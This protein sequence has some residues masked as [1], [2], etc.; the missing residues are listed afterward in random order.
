[1]KKNIKYLI[2]FVL[3]FG[4]S[5][6]N[7][8]AKSAFAESVK[9]FQSNININKNGTVSVEEVILYDFGTLQK[10]GIY[11]DIDIRKENQEG[12]AFKLDI[13]I[14]SVT[15]ENGNPYNYTTPSKSRYKSIKVGDADKLITGEHTY[16]IKYLV[17]GGI[18]YFSDHDEFYWNYT[19]VEWLVPIQSATAK[20]KFEDG[21]TGQFTDITCYVGT[22]GST[23]QDCFKNIDLVTKSNVVVSTSRELGTS[24]GITFVA[25]F[26][27]GLVEVLEPKQDRSGLVDTIIG[28]FFTILAILW[29]FVLPI[30]ILVD[31]LKEKTFTK[32]N[33]RIVAAWFEP[34]QFEDKTVFTPAETGFIIDK[35]IDHKEL[36]GTLIQLAQRGY[37]KIKHEEKKNFTFI[38]TK[39]YISDS[40]LR[41]FEKKILEGIFSGGDEVNVN[42]LKDSDKFMTNSQAFRKDVEEEL[43]NKKM[44]EK[45]PSTTEMS[46]IG[47]GM[48]ALFTMN[49]FLAFVCLVFGRK[50]SKRTLIGIEKYSEA[51]SL[52]N[53]LKSQDDKLD[54]QAQNQMFFEKLLSYA[55]AFGV[56]KVWAERFKDLKMIKPDWYEGNDFSDVMALSYMSHSLSTSVQTSMTPTSSSSGF[57]SGFSGGSSGGGGG[58]GGGGSW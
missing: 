30:K 10:H 52:F 18:T 6:S 50:S 47:L 7:N 53:F 41:D 46:M 14:Q 31:S 39:D 17:S 15:D 42:D 35:A 8:I 16:V 58:G 2:I 21:M 45:K 36:T 44:F 5:L 13:K 4:L 55:T 19:G 48:F 34:P 26:P 24:E 22:K 1:M 23:S 49:L 28:V 12:K 33:E 9:N 29:L 27:K 51:R 25:S 40:T 43:V 54:F 11:R 20:I 38:K 32:K 3:A 37:L 56:E 57:S